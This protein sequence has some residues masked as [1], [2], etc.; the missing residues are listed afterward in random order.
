M[1]ARK[2]EAGPPALIEGIVRTLTPPL[3]RES[4]LGD[5]AECY[6]SP[7]QYAWDAIAALPMIVASQVRRSSSLP[8]LGLQVFMLFACLGGFSAASAVT[9]PI[10][11]RAA[12]PTAAAMLTLILRDAY[13]TTDRYTIGR[14]IADGLIVTACVALTQG[15]LD[16]MQNVGGL[17]SNWIQPP[18]LL[19][20]AVLAPMMLC[21]LR[22]G[23][24]VDGDAKPARAGV[25][26]SEVAG[27]YAHFQ[28]RIRGR[29]II[30]LVIGI[31]CIAFTAFY[32]TRFQPAVA[33]YGW[34][35]LIGHASAML[36]IGARGWV[37][38]APSD[39]RLSRHYGRELTR[40]RIMRQYL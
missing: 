12:I 34:T 6:R 15:A 27:E 33:P 4:V 10:W 38:S 2:M 3:A 20:L 25:P 14:A 36:Y 35:M 1:E 30:E 11:L 37:R 17:E 24:G 28:R 32:L 5:F 7:M 39:A 8:V 31:A 40:L 16:L 9:P 21:V 18:S 22:F 26:G 23:L 29:N 19:V 13:R